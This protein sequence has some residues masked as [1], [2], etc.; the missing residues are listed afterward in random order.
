MKLRRISQAFKTSPVSTAL[1]SLSGIVLVVLLSVFVS[2]L[3][4][5]SA[6]KY[7]AQLLGVSE[8]GASKKYESLK[9]L[10][11][12]MGGVLLAL[13]ALIANRRAKAMEDTA[14][15]QVQANQNTERGQRQ[16]RL[17]NAIEHLGHDK[18]SVRLG[19]AYE[20]FH[21]AQD[22]KDLR[23]TVLDILCAHI[24][25]TT[26]E[27][28]YRKT[29]KSQP[30]EEIQSLLTLLFV[31]EHEAFKGLQIN[32][33]GSWLNGANLERACLVRAV[34]TGA[35]LQRAILSDANLQGTNLGGA[36]LQEAR[37]WRVSLQGATLEWAGLQEAHFRK[38]CLQGI[39]LHMA[40]LQGASLQAARLQ[41]AFLGGARLQGASLQDV[42]LQ[43]VRSRADD[44]P[45]PI[46]FAEHIRKHIGQESDLCRVTF[47]GG[48]NS[49]KV[50]E[51]VKDL[52]S[53]EEANELWNKLIPH[54]D[55]PS[56]H[57]LPENSGAITGAYTAE[58][59]EEWIA[60]YNE[61]MSEVP[62]SD[63]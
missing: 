22:T 58:E 47:E 24:R 30:S 10:G 15:A 11:I 34:L 3:F 20:L 16:E 56:S 28:E 38:A 1:V 41:G 17:K 60:E 40:R 45:P 63:D 50:E 59:A 29:Y 62:G 42:Q 31:Q 54:I 48:L 8:T 13:Q 27:A 26:G 57:E 52:S 55:R 33:Q 46:S 37:L 25:R 21:L 51:L 9:F 53:N 2:V 5:E 36:Y 18:D 32:L 19:G 35:H 39:N 4:C 61:A 12:G 7:I 14:R 44:R 23:Q 43:G 49:Q 6:E